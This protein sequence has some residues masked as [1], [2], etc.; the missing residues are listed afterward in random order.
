MHQRTQSKK[1]PTK[2]EKIFVNHMPD[3]G[4]VSKICEEYVTY[5]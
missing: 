5:Q 2:W 4:F 3:K 1:T